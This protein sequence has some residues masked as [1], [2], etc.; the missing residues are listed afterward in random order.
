MQI[1]SLPAL[2]FPPGR[3]RLRA[4]SATSDD[5]QIFD[6]LRGKW[7]VLTPEEWVRQNFVAMLAT[8][9]GY[10]PHR[11]RNEVGMRLNTTLRRVDTVVYDDAMRPLMLVEYKAPHIAVTQRVIDQIARYNLVLGAPWLAVSNGLNTYCCRVDVGGCV[12]VAAV[13]PYGELRR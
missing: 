11:M 13:P 1:A 9:L 12:F 5:A 7:V 3:V 6:P 10:S 4:T 8:D 2:N